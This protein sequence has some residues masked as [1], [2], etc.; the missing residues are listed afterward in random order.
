MGA[1]FLVDNSISP[2]N[3]NLALD[4]FQEMGF[5]LPQMIETG[6]LTIYVYPKMATCESNIYTENGYTIISIGTPI[7]KEFNYKDTL[8]SL[9]NDYIDQNISYESLT[10]HFS[11]MFCHAGKVEIIRDSLGSKHIFTDNKYH[12]ISS[13][14]LPICQCIEDDL[15]IN[16]EAFYEKFLTGFIMSPNTL[17]DE[18]VQIDDSIADIINNIDNGVNFTE[19]TRNV[20]IKPQSTTCKQCLVDQANELCSYFETLKNYSKNGVD[21]GLSG[22]YDSRLVLACLNKYTKEKIH[23]HSHSTEDVHKNDLKIAYKMAEYIGETCHIVNTKK[24]NHCE[25]IEEILR[26]S[27]L[28]FDGRSSYSIGGCGEVYTASYR[29]ESTEKTPFTL[30]GVGGELYRNVFDIGQK[31]IRFDEFLRNK[32]FSADFRKAVSDDLFQSISNS[33]ITRA[34]VRLNVNKHTKQSKAIAH[35]YYCEIMMPDGQGVALD[36]YNQVSCCIAPFMEP[37]IISKGYESVPFHCSGGEFEGQLI[38]YIDSVLASL[39]SSYGYPIGKRSLKAKIK[40]GIRTYIPVSIWNRISTIV[41]GKHSKA[42]ESSVIEELY[43][44]SKTIETAYT[45][46][47]QLFPEINFDCLLQSGENI[48]RIQFLAMTLYYFKE[49]I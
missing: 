2:N 22:G 7:Y 13:H 16:R 38:T 29:S 24:L 49:R 4:M 30:T 46:M 33:V 18:V 37:N 5:T 43:A 31:K 8:C 40:E 27:V 39:P 26:K 35:R 1:F 45:F 21:I 20:Q 3:H 44:N 42:E 48:R 41:Y 19:I 11:I 32:V 14:M 15:H 6:D 23:L 9:L 12:I 17:F 34:A 28:Y 10:G 25:N 47:V 36:A